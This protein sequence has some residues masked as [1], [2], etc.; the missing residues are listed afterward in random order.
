[1]TGISKVAKQEITMDN[2]KE[3]IKKL[4]DL[5][6]GEFFVLGSKESLEN[7]IVKNMIDEVNKK[8]DFIKLTP[9]NS[10]FVNGLMYNKN[11]IY[12][13]KNEMP[14]RLHFE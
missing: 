13:V 2:L 12:L 5:Y 11:T 7:E 1:M 8:Y 6:C 4:D 14:I 3:I 9:L 10:E